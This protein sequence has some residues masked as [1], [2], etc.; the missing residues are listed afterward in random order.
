MEAVDGY[1]MG[2]CVC[3]EH[4]RGKQRSCMITCVI[5]LYVVGV[6]LCDEQMIK[7]GWWRL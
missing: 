3:R 6:S 5:I 4:G 2:T 1:N 7:G